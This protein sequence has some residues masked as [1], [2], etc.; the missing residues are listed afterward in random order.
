MNGVVFVDVERA[1]GS[2]DPDTAHEEL[3]G[4]YRALTSKAVT[5]KTGGGGEGLYK[6]A[7]PVMVFAG[8]VIYACSVN[9]STYSYEDLADADFEQLAI[10]YLKTDQ[11]KNISKIAGFSTAP[12]IWNRIGNCS[13]NTVDYINANFSRL[14]LLQL[15]VGGFS[16]L[17]TAGLFV[18]NEIGRRLL[19]R[20]IPKE[21][22]YQVQREALLLARRVNRL[23]KEGRFSEAQKN[24]IKLV[25]KDFF[26]I[27]NRNRLILLFGAT[28]FLLDAGIKVGIGFWGERSLTSTQNPNDLYRLGF[29]DFCPHSSNCTAVLLGQK[30]VC[31]EYPPEFN[32]Y[33]VDHSTLSTS[34][35][36]EDV[37]LGWLGAML[38]LAQ[39]L[40]S[41]VPTIYR[42]TREAISSCRKP[43]WKASSSFIELQEEFE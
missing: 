1:L 41:Y 9:F 28:I 8:F 3:M 2:F 4:H 12:L 39:H 16:L 42:V 29:P 35:T 37:K 20:S 11:G 24:E 6:V 31:V 13:Y 34:T 7:I 43:R 15:K 26:W 32:Q 27:K 21:L 17:A 18:V 22:P 23:M 38:P 10:N 30:K 19:D 14:E 5:V 40:L 36:D 33:A 25:Q